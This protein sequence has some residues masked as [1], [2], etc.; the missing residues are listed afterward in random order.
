MNKKSRR[1][2]LKGFA[3]GAPAVWAKPIVDSVVLPAHAQ[4]SC[5]GGCFQTSNGGSSVLWNSELSEI[6]FYNG[7]TSCSGSDTNGP[8]PVIIGGIPEDAFAALSC[9][10]GLGV[11]VNLSSFTNIP[12]TIWFCD[13]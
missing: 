7:S 6:T 9:A 12:C 11:I 4:T 2:V 8:L 10:G 13:E 1:I 5:A 3:I